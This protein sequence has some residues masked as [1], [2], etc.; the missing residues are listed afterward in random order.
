MQLPNYHVMIRRGGQNQSF[1]AIF[2][3]TI[4]ELDLVSK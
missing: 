2:R 4:A 3:I 1:V